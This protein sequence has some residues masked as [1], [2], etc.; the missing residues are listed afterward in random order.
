MTAAAGRPRSGARRAG[1]GAARTVGAVRGRGQP[2]PRPD[3][4][5]T[6]LLAED[7]PELASLELYP[8][9]VA[10][11]GL[12]VIG[13]RARLAPAPNRTDGARRTQSGPPGA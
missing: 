10:Q 12:T 6:V 2:G 5:Q 8:V 4:R 11:H 9:L 7:L 13:A 3:H 1:Q